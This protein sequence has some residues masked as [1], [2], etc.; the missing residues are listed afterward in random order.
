[1][2]RASPVVEKAVVVSRPL[3]DVVVSNGLPVDS[4]PEIVVEILVVVV[5]VVSLGLSDIAVVVVVAAAVG[6]VVVVIR[7]S[8]QH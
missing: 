7:V 3:S 6:V 4:S 8:N 2:S 5:V 1:M